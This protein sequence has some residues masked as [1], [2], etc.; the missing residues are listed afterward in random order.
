MNEVS[1]EYNGVEVPSRA[2][3][4]SDGGN[5]SAEVPLRRLFEYLDFTVDWVEA[6]QE[7]IV[8][9][10]TTTLSFK[11][12][13]DT[14]DRDVNGILTRGIPLGGFARLVLDP[15]L[16]IPEIPRWVTV[17][18]LLSP[19]ESLGYSVRLRF[20]PTTVVISGP[21][22]RSPNVRDHLR[23]NGSFEVITE[24]NP[25]RGRR[26]DFRCTRCGDVFRSPENQ[27][28]E[29]LSANNYRNYLRVKALLCAVPFY[30]H[31]DNRF[32][33]TEVGQFLKEIDDIRGA[34]PRHSYE[35]SDE[36]GDY[37]PLFRNMHVP[38]RRSGLVVTPNT[39]TRFGQFI[40]TFL[41][42]G[43]F[44]AGFF[45]PSHK[46]DNF[47]VLKA[48]LSESVQD[49]PG[50]LISHLFSIHPS[51]EINRLGKIL[52]IRST[53]NSLGKRDN[54]NIGDHVVLIYNLAYGVLNPVTTVVF[55]AN[56][57]ELVY[58]EHH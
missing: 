10:D 55:D 26:G 40:N 28:R 24:T 57:L 9:N 1:I 37:V 41:K 5:L 35:Y 17:I 46:K 51:P 42:I 16:I 14:F 48:M 29:V 3:L 12:D 31:V 19:L 33:H 54:P 44:V 47:L 8:Y 45:I 58:I 23:D 43:L 52:D 25:I 30:A 38:D 56:S 2:T 20:N 22:R 50:V 11:I 6:T 34:A 53:F 7:V 18:P 32:T 21:C 13:A 49:I 36:N 4:V 27:D 15:T 39:I